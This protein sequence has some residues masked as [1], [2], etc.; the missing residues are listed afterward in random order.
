MPQIISIIVPVYNL[1]GYIQHTLD[2][3]FAQTHKEL[4]VIAVDDGSTDRTPQIL[5]DYAVHE[6]RLCVIHQANGGVS[7]ARNAGLAVASGD[8]ISFLDGDDEVEPTMYE[9]LLANLLKYDADISHCGIL[10]EGLDGKTRYF[11]NTGVLEVHSREEGLLEILKG[12]KVEPS[13]GNKLY[14]KELFHRLLFD[15][16]ILYNE[17]LLMNFYLFSQAKCS[18][19]EDVCLYHYIRRPGSA[20]KSEVAEKHVFHPVE[21][22]RRI[23][24]L[25][26]GESSAIRNTAT[27]NYLHANMSAYGLVL[28]KRACQFRRFKEGFRRNILEK[29]ADIPLLNRSGR[30]HA[31]L[32]LYVPFLC[33]PVFQLYYYFFHK[34]QYG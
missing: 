13:L 33:G 17:D 3:L 23:M 26:S 20:C 4:E 5:D 31:W 32:I 15:E 29:R 6:P 10:T 25:C 16:K 1:E 7:A 24:Q 28:E 19:F 12:Q 27:S 14:R 30:L 34:K 2:T 11:H 9:R 8:Y 18:V 22:R 21:V